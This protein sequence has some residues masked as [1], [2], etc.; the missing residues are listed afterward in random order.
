MNATEFQD[1]RQ[2]AAVVLI[3]DKD[4]VLLIHRI[5]RT[6]DPWSGQIALPG[7]FRKPEE[8]LRETA[9]RE[10][11]EEVGILP[12]LSGFAGTYGT[13]RG[14]KKVAVF[15]S[16]VNGEPERN[17][18]PEVADIHWVRLSE[19]KTGITSLKFPSLDYWGG[20]IWGLTYRILMDNIREIK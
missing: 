5:E 2:D 3:T 19:L 11:M 9:R 10:A 15:Y 6:G 14:Q 20:Q 12:D 4:H 8:D 18:G 7:G 17:K 13:Y 1:I 16:V